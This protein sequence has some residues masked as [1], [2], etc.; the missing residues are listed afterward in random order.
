MVNITHYSSFD[1]PFS[2]LSDPEEAEALYRQAAQLNDP[3]SMV[4]LGDLLR[5]K[6]PESAETWYRKAAEL[7]D[8]KAIAR[9][10]ELLKEKKSEKAKKLVSKDS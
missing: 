2:P 9:L 4:K 1:P 7:K 8:K 5:E 10:D 3:A 6:K